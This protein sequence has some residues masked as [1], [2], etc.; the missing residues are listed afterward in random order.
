MESLDVIE[1]VTGPTSWVNSMVTTKPNS[2][3]RICIDPCNLNEAIQR[4]HYPMQTIEEVITRIPETTYFSVL[5]ASSRYWQISL[6]QESAKLCTFNSPFGHYMFKRLPFCLPSVQDI[7]Q[8][9]M[10]EMFED[11]EGVEV[12]VD[13]ILVWGTNEAEHDSRLIK[14]LDRAHLRNLKLNKT[15]CQFKKQEIAYLGH[16]LTKDGLK[17]DP[18]KTQAISEIKPPMRNQ[19]PEVSSYG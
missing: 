14:V 19:Q 7:F 2:S 18:K 17:P 5:D 6:D 4:E 11:T 16:V 13:D 8:K 1:K 15:K 9:V 12:V 10:T 3:L